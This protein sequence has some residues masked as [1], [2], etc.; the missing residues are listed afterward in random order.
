[1]GR[2]DCFGLEF[3]GADENVCPHMEC[4]LRDECKGVHIASLGVVHKR[5]QRI[6]EEDLKSKEDDRKIKE[7]KLELIEESFSSS[8]K[9]PRKRGYKK[10][11]KILYRDEGT[12]RDRFLSRIRKCLTKN[13]Y[14]V[15]A[16]KCIHSF[17]RG[18][19]YLLKIDTRRKKSILVFMRDDLSDELTDR[20]IKCRGLYDS[21]RANYP[22]YIKWVSKISS[23]TEMNR[24]MESIDSCYSLK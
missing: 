19:E 23:E 11:G 6:L 15:R 16:T 4:I 2:P 20:G 22:I 17:D 18:G 12:T 10:P 5:R 24:L 8:T 3:Y 13:S 1:M 14:R 7:R 21:E 9:K